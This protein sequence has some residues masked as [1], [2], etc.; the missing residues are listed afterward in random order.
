MSQPFHS[1]F[2]LIP[3]VKRN[4]P[5]W[6]Y[7][8][9]TWPQEIDPLVHKLIDGDITGPICYTRK[10]NRNNTIQN[11]KIVKY[12]NGDIIM[13]PGDT[14]NYHVKRY[15]TKNKQSE[16]NNDEVPHEMMCV[17]CLEN[18]ITHVLY[19]CNH[20]VLCGKCADIIYNDDQKCP[21][22]REEMTMKPGKLFFV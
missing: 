5:N 8:E 3:N 22:C 7:R 11:C 13:E 2:K 1:D 9:A 12:P 19:D 14:F 21:M 4:Q 10:K 20:F 17:I 6:E 15:E 16:I 18:K